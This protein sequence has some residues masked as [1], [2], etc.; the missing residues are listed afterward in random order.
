M[1]D[2]TQRK[3]ADQQPEKIR[4]AFSEAWK[5]VSDVP[6]TPDIDRQYQLTLEHPEM[7]RRFLDAC[8]K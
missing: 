4:R 7:R 1:L 6:E 8:V 2:F 3:P 5:P